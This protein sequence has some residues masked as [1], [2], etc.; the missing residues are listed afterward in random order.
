MSSAVHLDALDGVSYVIFPDGTISAVGTARWNKF[1]CENAAP[2]LLDDRVVGRNLFEFVSGADAHSHIRRLLAELSAERR[3]VCVAPLRCDAPA[4]L[5]YMRQAIT[6]IFEGH[7]CRGFLFQS[8]ELE[9]HQRPPIDDFKE[10]RR[11]TGE[12]TSLPL[13]VMCSWCLRVQSP[14]GDC[15]MRAEDYY[16]AGGRSGVRISHGICETCVRIAFPDT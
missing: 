7:E 6:P 11:R 12:F 2:E 10:H 8:I 1:A 9:S 4:R 15:W 13:V 3:E 14:T 16:A 5:R